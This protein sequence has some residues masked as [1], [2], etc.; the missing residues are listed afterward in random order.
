M[1]DTNT[2]YL[3]LVMTVFVLM[4]VLFVHR[5]HMNEQVRRKQGEVEDFTNRLNQKMEVLDTEIVDL[6]MKIDELDEEIE[7]YNA[8]AQETE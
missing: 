4:T 6:K 2:L 5:H 3:I 7:F 8:P 1:L